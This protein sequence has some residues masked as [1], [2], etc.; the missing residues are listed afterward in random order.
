MSELGEF[1]RTRRAAIRPEDY[2]LLAGPAARRRVP[3]LRREELALLAGISIDYYVRLEQGRTRNVSDEVLEAVAD[4]LQ[5]GPDERV[6]LRNLARPAP[7]KRH[8]PRPQRVRPGLRRLLECAHDVPAFVLGRR[9]DVLAWNPLARLVV[10]DFDRLPPAD[11]NIARLVFLHDGPERYPEFEAVAKEVVGNLR[12]YAGRHPDDPAMATLI[13]ELSLGSV[14]FT[15]LW[16]GFTIREKAHG[17]KVIRHPAVGEFRLEYE[18]LQLPDDPEQ[19][20]VTYTA[21]AG[22]DSETSLRLLA[23]LGA[24]AADGRAAVRRSERI[25]R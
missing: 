25:F 20:L 10:A 12:S 19:M 16:S 6:Y 22:S 13:G 24:G 9:M 15:R 2:G 11:R 3:G 21:A 18:T 23:G 4:A 1:L 5:L 8:T 17:S 7:R 14:E